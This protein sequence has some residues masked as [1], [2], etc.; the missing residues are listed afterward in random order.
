MFHNVTYTPIGMTTTL[1]GQEMGCV[2]AILLSST[3]LSLYVSSCLYISAFQED[4]ATT[5]EKIDQMTPSLPK[6]LRKMQMQSIENIELQVKSI[7]LVNFLPYN[8]E[9]PTLLCL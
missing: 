8:D 6:T 1:I 7:Q 2:C 5:I 4:V 9:I 3:Y